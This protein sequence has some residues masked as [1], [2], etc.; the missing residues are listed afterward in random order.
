MTPNSCTFLKYGVY[1]PILSLKI[2]SFAFAPMCFHSSLP[3]SFQRSVV[4]T[5]Y[6]QVELSSLYFGLAGF[7]FLGPQCCWSFPWIRALSRWLLLPETV[8][9]RQQLPCAWRSSRAVLRE[10]SK[11]CSLPRNTNFKFHFICPPVDCGKLL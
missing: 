11:P 1:S 10:L 2:I 9:K 8:F 7:V 4:Q 5:T 3:P 6:L